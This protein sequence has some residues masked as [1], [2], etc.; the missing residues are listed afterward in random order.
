VPDHDGAAAPLTYAVGTETATVS[1][2]VNPDT[3]RGWVRLA[4]VPVAE[5]A[6]VTLTVSEA[7][8]PAYADAVMAMINRQASPD[9]E[10][11]IPVR[12]EPVG[13]ETPGADDLHLTSYPN[14]ARATVTLQLT[15][16]AP[17]PVELALYDVLGRRVRAVLT[18]HRRPAGSHAVRLATDGLAP[19]VYVAR[20]QVGSRTATHALTLL[21]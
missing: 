13:P 10:I 1:T 20:L 21:P 15:L 6:T 4:S 14:P 3:A 8:Q 12:R 18:G 17:A 2:D 11:A 19:G 7:T 16:P 5:Q 9:A